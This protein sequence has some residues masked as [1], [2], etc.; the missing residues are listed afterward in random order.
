VSLPVRIDRCVCQRLPFALVL[1]LA[2]AGDWS[3][4]DVVRETGC[5]DQCGMCRP[6]LRQMLATGRTIFSEVLEDEA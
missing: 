5:G 3:V 4:G 6:Y 1:Q 2:R